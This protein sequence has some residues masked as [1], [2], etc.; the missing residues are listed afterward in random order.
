MEKKN[1]I[2]IGRDILEKHGRLYDDFY[3]DKVFLEKDVYK[4]I[5]NARFIKDHGAL[6][7]K[8]GVVK[9]TAGDNSIYRKFYGGNSVNINNK[10]AGLLS[11][12]IDILFRGEFKEKSEVTIR[13]V[14]N[15]FE[16]FLFYWK[17]PV[18]STRVSFKAGMYYCIIS[19]IIGGFVI[20]VML[21]FIL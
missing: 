4:K 18:D 9:I 12:S 16:K 17:H 2:L 3:R 19:I 21:K 11:D 5:F 10:Q 13:A 20:P 8:R 1:L 7:W 15:P 14:K 6:P